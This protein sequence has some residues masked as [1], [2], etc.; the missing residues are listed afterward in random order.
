MVSADLA[1]AV[2][3]LAPDERLE[4]ARRLVESVVAP[5][6]LSEAHAR[7]HSPHRGCRERTRRRLDRGTVSRPRM[8]VLFHPD[9]PKDVRRFQSEY[10]GISIGLGVRFRRELDEAVDAIKKITEERWSFRESR[11]EGRP[12]TPSPQSQRVSILRNLWR[13]G[14]PDDRMIFG[15][16]IPSRSDPLTWLTRFK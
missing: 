12:R 5:E 13:H 11:L 9:F 16:V 15:A 3:E 4:L 14:R 2:L 8:R 10:A 7:R 6:P 1:K